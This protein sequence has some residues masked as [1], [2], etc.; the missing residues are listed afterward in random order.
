MF[1]GYQLST[2]RTGELADCWVWLVGSGL[3]DHNLMRWQAVAKA[4]VVDLAV[5]G[6]RRRYPSSL[7]FKPALTRV[8]FGLHSNNEGDSSIQFIAEL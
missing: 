2:C 5:F 8:D 6:A 4:V 1:I 3:A 7:Q